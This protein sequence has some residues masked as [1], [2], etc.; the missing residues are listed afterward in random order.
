MKKLTNQHIIDF[1][2]KI[3]GEMKSMH[4]KL[5]I[6]II[7][8]SILLTTT[9]LLHPAMASEFKDVQ[10]S[11][12]NK[13]EITWCVTQNI[14]NGY[15][16]NTFRPD[17]YISTNAFQIMLNQAFASNAYQDIA[18]NLT[19]YDAAYL[20]NQVLQEYDINPDKYEIMAAG[21]SIKDFNSIPKKYKDSIQNLYALNIMRGLQDKKFHGEKN[22]TRAQ[23][24][25]ILYRT[26]NLIQAQDLPLSINP[27]LSNGKAINQENVIEFI[28][29]IKAKYPGNTSW[30]GYKKL[31]GVKFEKNAIRE[32]IESYAVTGTEDDKCSTDTGCGG[33]AAYVLDYIFG[34]DANFRKISMDEIHPGDLMLRLDAAN[35]LA[36]VQIYIGET[37]NKNIR[38]SNANNGLG[39]PTAAGTTSY[40]I[41]WTN[42]LPKND[43]YD[44]YTAYPE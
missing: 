8:L 30:P 14:L 1:A 25:V 37:S 22:I 12:P 41:I 2:N 27:V 13:L 31:E 32:I 23:A 5:T 26:A 36:H 16:D 17:A 7:T 6:V 40:K 35:K 21:K 18:S 34:Q 4:K 43:K 28:T 20:I 11:H 38:I 29:E 19:R 44:I 33:W 39:V 42:I 15:K 3:L 10:E 24:A 9:N